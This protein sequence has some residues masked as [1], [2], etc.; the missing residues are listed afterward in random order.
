MSIVK[1]PVEAPW[2]VNASDPADIHYPQGF[3]V[4]DGWPNVTTPPARQFF[5]W[6]LN[7]CMSGYRYL[8]QR[9]VPEW[10]TNEAYPLGA[11][12]RG[13][14]DGL[15]YECLVDNQSGHEPSVSPA[16]W[17]PMNAVTPPSGDNSTK[18]ATTAFVRGDYVRK[19]TQ[20][21]GYQTNNT[22]ANPTWTGSAG[23]SLITRTGV[24][25]YKF[26]HNL[27]TA[28]F[29][30]MPT[31]NAVVNTLLKATSNPANNTST[32][33]FVEVQDF[34]INAPADPPAGGGISILL[35]VP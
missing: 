29:V 14:V 25:R 24:G 19:A 20:L 10:D 11:V 1:P 35:V 27:G 17:G 31:V 5:N 21:T 16:D 13:T 26:T 3:S 33:F 12:V 7:R 30:V 22:A 28:N 4:G 6:I 15:L 2:A 32:F 8:C 9:G 18:V 34:N 23:V